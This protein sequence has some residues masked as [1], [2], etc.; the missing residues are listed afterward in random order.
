[1]FIVNIWIYN[2]YIYDMDRT[3][4]WSGSIHYLI[5]DFKIKA[6]LSK[7]DF[8]IL[9]KDRYKLSIIFIFVQKNCMFNSKEIG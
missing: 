1:M 7:Y 2:A 6:P 8:S 3:V 9:L 4:H 5:M